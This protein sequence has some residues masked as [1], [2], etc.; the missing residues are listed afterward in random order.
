MSL[1]AGKEVFFSGEDNLSV[2]STS[3]WAERGFCNVCGTAIFYKL[4]ETSDYHI[5]VWLFEQAE[6]FA[7]ALR[8]FTDKKPDSYAF[9]NQTP[10]M[11]EA[12]VF[13]QHASNT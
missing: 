4:K 8:I 13:D 1:A 6:N 3:N 10:M 9:E 12:E 5:P 11:T 2:Y 7:F